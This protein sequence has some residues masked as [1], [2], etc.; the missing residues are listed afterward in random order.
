MAARFARAIAAEV[1]AG[2]FCVRSEGPNANGGGRRSSGWRHA[3][4]LDSLLK[5]QFSYLSLT[6]EE[7]P[8]AVAAYG[9][10]GCA[11]FFL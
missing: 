4:G 5:I 3:P 8:R 7:G 10:L 2:R 1:L 9:Q 11:T 6:L